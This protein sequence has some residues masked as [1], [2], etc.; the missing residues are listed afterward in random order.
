MDGEFKVDAI[1][2]KSGEKINPFIFDIPTSLFGP[3]NGADAHL[4]FSMKLPKPGIWQLSA[5]ID[6]KLFGSINVEVK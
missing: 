4:P 6:E 5:F 2:I 3:N 1:N